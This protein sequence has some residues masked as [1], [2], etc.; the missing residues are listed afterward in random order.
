MKT[1]W[2]RYRSLP[3]RVYPRPQQSVPE[4]RGC[5]TIETPESAGVH[6]GIYKEKAAETAAFAGVAFL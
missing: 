5:P 2:E 4:L 1:W 6:A 3:I